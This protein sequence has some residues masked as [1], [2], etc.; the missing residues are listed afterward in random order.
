MNRSIGIVIIFL[1]LSACRTFHPSK[2]SCLAH[3]NEPSA[4]ASATPC[5]DDCLRVYL[6]ARGRTPIRNVCLCRRFCNG[7]SNALFYHVLLPKSADFSFQGLV[8]TNLD[9]LTQ[10]GATSWCN[11]DLYTYHLCSL[12]NRPHHVTSKRIQEQ[13]GNDTGW[14]L[15]GTR[16]Q[17]L[18]D[19]KQHYCFAHPSVMLHGINH[20]IWEM[21]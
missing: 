19:P 6:S 13:Q 15:F 21:W 9:W 8:D 14:G 7:V 20:I 18:F 11:L 16:V 5:I 10:P 3:Q 12:S 1:F 17:N 4:R 2:R